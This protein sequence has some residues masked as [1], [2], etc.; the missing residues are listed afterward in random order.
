[1]AVGSVHVDTSLDTDGDTIVPGAGIVWKFLSFG[2]SMEATNI[3]LQI[4]RVSDGND[5]RLTQKGTSDNGS[6]S[7][8]LGNPSAG[9]TMHTFAQIPIIL[10]ETVAL[11]LSGTPGGSHLTYASYVIL[12]E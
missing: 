8:F 10:D 5:M 4:A 12:E 3:S 1:M 11:R 9:T 6:F 7:V 2:T